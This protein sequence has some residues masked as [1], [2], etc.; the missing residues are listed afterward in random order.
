MNRLPQLAALDLTASALKA[1]SVLFFAAVAGSAH[2]GEWNTSIG[3]QGTLTLTD[4]VLLAPPGREDP[5]LYL[6]LTVPLS[7]SREGARMRFQAAYIPTL[8]I[9]ADH[10]ESDELQNYLQSLLTVEAVED[11]FFID[12]SADITQTYISPFFARPA[13]GGNITNNRTETATLGLSPYITGV[14]RHG[15]SYLARNDNRWTAYDDERLNG[16]FTSRILVT[17]ESPQARLRYG[18]D[19]DSRYTEYDNQPNSYYEQLARLRPILTVSPTL[20]V[21]GRVGY[22][23]NDYPFSSSEGVIYGAGLD[24]APTPRTRLVGFAEE[25][26]F[27]LSYGLD[28]GHRTRVTDWALTASRNTYTSVEALLTLPPGT[29]QQVLDR[30]LLA[31]IPDPI[32]RQQTVGELLARAGLPPELISPFT[33]YTNQIYLS[34]HVA[35]SV[36]LVGRRNLATLRLFYEDTKPITAAGDELPALSVFNSVRQRG[37]R[38]GVSHKLSARSSVS[39]S[40]E[41]IYALGTNRTTTTGEQR[42]E[43]IQDTL[44]LIFTRQLSARTYA[45]TG[46]RWQENDSNISPYRETA[47]FASISHTF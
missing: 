2:A 39:F 17:V 8:F 5:D 15:F 6:G 19:Y 38:L 9:Y 35:A 27:G 29:T 34:E 26:Y 43:S 10:S 14:T 42:I 46:A 3:A 30:A 16:S 40:A 41:R 47:V 24:W 22:E 32:Q 1:S 25:R 11:F 36:S 28:L 21:S 7:V 31:R 23:T 12:A 13:G 4:N 37:V 33:F 20:S 45:S 18:A 44:H